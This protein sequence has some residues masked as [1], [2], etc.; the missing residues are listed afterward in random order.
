MPRNRSRRARNPSAS[1]SAAADREGETL[2][3]L[4]EAAPAS[5]ISPEEA[6]ALFAPLLRFEALLLAV[7]GG[8][9]SMAMLELAAAWARRAGPSAPKVFVATVDHGLRPQSR[10]EAEFVAAR[11][12][13]L[14]L[15]HAALTWVAEKPLTGVA[16]AARDARYALLARRAR[17]IA[18]AGGAAIVTAHTQDDQAETVLMRLARGS[19]VDG[20]AA[21]AR[22]RALDADGRA[23]LA[24]PL[25][26]VSKARLIATL[27]VAGLPWCEDPSNA[28][29]ASERV[30]LRNAL[31]D[32]AAVGVTA[33][34]IATTARRMG[35]ARA[36]LAYA[37]R[38]F[39][40]SL[41]IDFHDEIFSSI[42]RVPFAAAPELL[43]V[44]LLTR[45]IARFGGATP[46]P[47]LAEIEALAARLA[48]RSDVR[49]T[50]GGVVVS[51][52][53]R[54][55][56]VWRELGRLDRAGVALPPATPV[57]WDN[58]FVVRRDGGDDLA[59]VL[60]PLGAEGLAQLAPVWRRSR[61]PPATAVASQPA[62]WIGGELIG[63]PSLSAL[64][65]IDLPPMRFGLA[66]SAAPA[67]AAVKQ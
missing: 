66:V 6:D 13:A 67:A 15:E 52:S 14:D 9:D 8:P 65:A 37:D 42:D 59:V 61:R 58:R 43:R 47:R 48:A 33:P 46:P 24:R 49:A 25:L 56:K 35:E 11:C 38:T 57:L 1:A 27:E 26:A 31:V 16:S 7:S 30:R 3:R 55:L 18:P 44:R 20:L 2:A 23:T 28:N 50:L 40:T 62:V 60:R 10:A 54:T 64:A 12:V 5:P 34:A 63:A 17:A 39:E 41:N 21:M 29:D 51:A 22:C 53:A 36:A 45:L 4:T 32:L 19:G